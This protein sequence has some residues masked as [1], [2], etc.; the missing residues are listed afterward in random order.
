MKLSQLQQLFARDTVELFQYIQSKGFSFTYGE[1][2]RSPEQAALYAKEGKGIMD[3][4][5]CER[6]AIDINLFDADGNYLT[7]SKYYKDFG[8]FWENL[9]PS[10]RWGGKFHHKDGTAF[11]DANHFE[12]NEKPGK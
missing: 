5:H 10:N 7:D 1:A 12:R 6:L 4:L 11:P 3:S 8:L 9:C 2:M